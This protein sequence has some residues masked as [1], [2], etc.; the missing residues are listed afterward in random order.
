MQKKN[1]SSQTFTNDTNK[2]PGSNKAFIN[3]SFEP[4]LYAN[5]VIYRL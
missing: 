4:Q 1:L 5:L 2:T 3:Y